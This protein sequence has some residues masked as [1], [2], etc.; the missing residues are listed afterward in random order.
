MPEPSENVACESPVMRKHF[1]WR[2]CQ[3]SPLQTPPAA[4]AHH[5]VAFANALLYPA[6]PQISRGAG[7]AAKITY[8]RCPQQFSPSSGPSP[9][10]P[11][12]LVGVAVV[13]GPWCGAGGGNRTGLGVYMVFPW[14]DPQLW[15]FFP[16]PDPT[17][18]VQAVLPAWLA[19]SGLFQCHTWV[20]M[21]AKDKT[22]K[23]IGAI[24]ATKGNYCTFRHRMALSL[25]LHHSSTRL[26]FI[27]RYIPSSC[28]MPNGT[29]TVITRQTHSCFFLPGQ[30]LPSAVM[31]LEVPAV[32]TQ[33]PATASMHGALRE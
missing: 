6:K 23:R 4:Y 7:R 29:S 22:E 26:P 10:A 21:T 25:G 17:S 14:D 18:F 28:Q 2:T 11:S 8:E 12:G 30:F 27:A 32:I 33:Q 3:L 5:A 31:A 24:G 16:L 9:C 20:G 13:V 19:L 1:P 15:G